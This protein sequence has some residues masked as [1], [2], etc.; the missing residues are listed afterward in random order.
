MFPLLWRSCTQDTQHPSLATDVTTGLYIPR[1]IGHTA[2]RNLKLPLLF[3]A[4][5]VFGDFFWSESSRWYCDIASAGGVFRLIGWTR[6]VTPKA[7][8]R[9]RLLC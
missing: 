5:L 6:F 2:G 1:G 4:G 9:C 8:S 3:A 7:Q